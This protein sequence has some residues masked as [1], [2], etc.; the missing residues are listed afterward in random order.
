MSIAARTRAV[1]QAPS[2]AH[3]AQVNHTYVAKLELAQNQPTL[4][5]LARLA[6]GLGIALPAMIEATLARTPRKSSAADRQARAKKVQAGERP[7]RARP[8]KTGKRG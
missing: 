6:A 7:T 1:F 3:Q 4:T 5:V 8:L 2:L